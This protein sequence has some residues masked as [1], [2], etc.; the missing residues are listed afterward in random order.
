MKLTLGKFTFGSPAFA[1]LS[2]EAFAN[3]SE[4]DRR[5]ALIGAIA[6]AAILLFGVIVPLDRTVTRERAKLAQKR[7]DLAWMQ[8]VAPEIARTAPPPSAT[9]ESLLVIID[10]SARES[11]L[12]NALAGSEPLAGGSL[13]IRLEKASFDALIGWL[14]R[15]SQ[16]NG[17]LVDSATIEKAGAPGLVNAAIVL[18]SG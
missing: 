3:L 14:A 13:S 18:H 2:P 1:G 15:L 12:G 8:S 16:Q 5:V 4:R 9:G 6:L 17:V 10:R 7:A 11:G